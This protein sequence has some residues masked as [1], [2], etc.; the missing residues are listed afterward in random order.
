MGANEILPSGGVMA[1]GRASNTVT[2]ADVTDSLVGKVVIQVGERS[3]DPVITPA[4]V[5]SCH[6]DDKF[7]DLA[8][9]GRSAW[10]LPVFQLVEFPS[11]R[12]PV[13]TQDRVRFADAGDPRQRSAAQS[14]ADLGKRGSLRIG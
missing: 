8:S 11:D 10:I 14:F 4:G 5:L 2:T 7:D 1:L 3:D 9:N 12:P 6:L 13:L